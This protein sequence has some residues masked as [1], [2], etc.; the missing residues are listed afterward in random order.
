MYLNHT[1]SLLVCNVNFIIGCLNGGGQIK[2]S[3]G[4]DPKD[5]LAKVELAYQSTR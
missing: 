3:S 4:E 2:P 1:L 5:R